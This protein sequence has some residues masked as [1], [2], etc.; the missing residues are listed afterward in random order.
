M[1]DEMLFVPQNVSKIS[2]TQRTLKVLR[3]QENAIAQVVERWNSFAKIRV[4]LF[5][6]IDIFAIRGGEL[7]G[8]QVTSGSNHGA[9]VA[10]IR[11][12][13]YA[14]PFCLAGGIIEV[15]SWSKRGKRGERKKWVE[16][17]EKITI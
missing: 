17:V 7:V 5:G 4:D 2:P 9:R 12:N 13:P 10:K 11:N 3:E 14:V 16:R 6:F 8:I 1:R 15:R